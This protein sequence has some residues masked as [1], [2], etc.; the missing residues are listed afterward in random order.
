[1]NLEQYPPAKSGEEEDVMDAT[2]IGEQIQYGTP[3]GTTDQRQ[4]EGKDHIP[5]YV[6][7]MQEMLRERKKA[8]PVQPVRKNTVQ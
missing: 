1:M 7:D 8:Q 3:D 4:E 2:I 6:E 5:H